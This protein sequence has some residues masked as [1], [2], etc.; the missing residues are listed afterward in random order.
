MNALVARMVRAAK[1]DAT[2]YEEVEGD[3]G[4]RLQALGVVIISSIAFGLG[5]GAGVGGLVTGTIASIL[6]WYLW[7]F[8][9]YIIGTRLLPEPTTRADHG[10]LLRT[11][12]FANAPGVISVLGIIPGLRAIVIAVAQ[13]WMLVAAIVAIRAALDYQS[14]WRAVA[15]VVI[16]WIVRL[17]LIILLVSLFGGPRAAAV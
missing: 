4:S 1:L 3:R 14:V 13:V 11:M 15:V 16:G 9:T 2:L 6:G 5:T 7:A 17:V 12:G 8:I 10:E